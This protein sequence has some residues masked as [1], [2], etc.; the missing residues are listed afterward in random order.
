MGK[1]KNLISNRWG[2]CASVLSLLFALS[3]CSEVDG[4]GSEP[5]TAGGITADLQAFDNPET[6]DGSILTDGIEFPFQEPVE[7]SAA[8]AES[9]RSTAHNSFGSAISDDAQ[10]VVFESDLDSENPNDVS[11][12]FVYDSV[13]GSIA[14]IGGS[15]V[16]LDGN[17]GSASLS[18]NGDL[19]AFES[20]ASNLYAGDGNTTRDI[21]VYNRTTATVERISESNLGTDADGASRSPQISADGRFVV[22][23]SEARNLVTNDTNSSADVFVHDLVENETK[24]LSNDSTSATDRRRRDPY[25]EPDISGTGRFVVFT[26]YNSLTPDPTRTGVS[27]IYLHDRDENTTQLIS[28]GVDDEASDRHSIEPSISNDGRFVVFS[29][30]GSN[31]VQED[32]NHKSDIFLFDREADTLV[33]LSGSFAEADSNLGDSFNPQIS[34]D[35]KNVIFQSVRSSAGG[36]VSSFDLFLV[37][38][39]SGQGSRAIQSPAEN[40]RNQ[41]SISGNGDFVTYTSVASNQNSEVSSSAVFVVKINQ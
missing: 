24:M 3:S 40:D 32:G 27:N 11:Y 4:P 29:S 15:D 7:I 1:L 14:R 20:N 10:I 25:G 19:I 9:V 12:L 35:G 33:S 26:S 21:F 34:G 13:D 31:L 5:Q 23:I 38:T 18:A 16:A 17:S 6:G 36:E 2:I 37:E 8:K 30:S 39:D 28:I 22:F 41:P